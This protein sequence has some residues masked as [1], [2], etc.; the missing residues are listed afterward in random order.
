MMMIIII[1]II[2]TTTIIIIIIIIII[3]SCGPEILSWCP[4][5]N[6]HVSWAGEVLF[7]LGWQSPRDCVLIKILVVVQP[8]NTLSVQ[9]KRLKKKND[10]ASS[11][12]HMPRDASPLGHQGGSKNELLFRTL[13]ELIWIL[14]KTGNAPILALQ[15]QHQLIQ[16]LK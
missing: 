8:Y 2:I 4:V 13:Q 1:I 10:T 6:R 12:V 9:L 15:S 5:G 14:T 11:V 3:N 7:S 16:D